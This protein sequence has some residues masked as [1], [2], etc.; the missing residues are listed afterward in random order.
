VYIGRYCF[1]KPNKENIKRIKIISKSSSLLSA[2]MEI[3]VRLS[4]RR[5][6]NSSGQMGNI[7]TT[8]HQVL[9][10][11]QIINKCINNF[12]NNYFLA[13]QLSLAPPIFNL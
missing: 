7:Y 3:K 4:R 8:L 1:N 5:L 13:G 11:F 10:Y 12:K 2:V 6:R 9:A